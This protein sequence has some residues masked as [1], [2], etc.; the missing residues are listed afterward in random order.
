MSQASNSPHPHPYLASAQTSDRMET[1][2]NPGQ[3]ACS[4]PSE[5]APD[6]DSTWTVK[7]GG[8]SSAGVAVGAPCL[9]RWL[10][11]HPF[12][13][14]PPPPWSRD[15]SLLDK[16]DCTGFQTC[17][18]PSSNEPNLPY[19]CSPTSHEKAVDAPGLGPLE[20]SS[21]FTPTYN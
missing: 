16:G 12:R 3:A 13:L 21:C 10:G 1:T 20:S 4:G 19:T 14:P 11:P 6:R 15:V 18:S 7:A 9:L 17:Q 2:D 5:E 8:S